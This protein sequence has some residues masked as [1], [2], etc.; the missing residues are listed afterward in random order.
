MRLFLQ[1]ALTN[2]GLRQSITSL[3]VMF[4]MGTIFSSSASPQQVSVSLQ[5]KGE[6]G[7]VQKD[8]TLGGA[9]VDF[10]HGSWSYSVKMVDNGAQQCKTTDG[11]SSGSGHRWT[12]STSHFYGGTSTD[13]LILGVATTGNICGY[14]A[15]TKYLASGCNT[16]SYICWW[17]ANRPTNWHK[18][19]FFPPDTGASAV[20]MSTTSGS[21]TLVIMLTIT[22]IIAAL[23]LQKKRLKGMA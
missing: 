10:S 22:G 12:C 5:I 8:V 1:R 3:V 23:L 17:Q 19:Y 2:R 13:T 15:D 6:S 18:I 4:S 16:R 14:E 21:A 9:W 11:C 7:F 20:P